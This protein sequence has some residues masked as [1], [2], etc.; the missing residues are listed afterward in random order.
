MLRQKSDT[1]KELFRKINA[2]LNV[3]LLRSGDTLQDAYRKINRQLGSAYLRFGSDNI[4]DAVRK[5]NTRLFDARVDLPAN[6]AALIPGYSVRDI[7]GTITIDWAPQDLVPLP[8]D[9]G[10]ATFYW[11]VNAANDSGDGLTPATAKGFLY[12]AFALG[13]ASAATS[14]SI[15]MV[16]GT[17]GPRGRNHH[18]GTTAVLPTKPFRLYSSDGTDVT[19]IAGTNGTWT[20]D[21]G[22]TYQRTLSGCGEVVDLVNNDAYGAPLAFTKVGSQATCRSTP[23]SW[24][25]SGTITYVNRGDA[26]A[27]TNTNT[28]CLLQATAGGLKNTTSG[29]CWIENV[30][31]VGGTDG[32]FKLGGNA[33]GRVLLKNCSA[34]WSTNSAGDTDGVQALDIGLVVLDRCKGAWNDK[35]AFNFH[36][37]NS[38]VPKAVLVDCSAWENG[39][40]ATNTSCNGPTIHD[41]G[42]MLDIRGT[43]HHNQGASCAH[44]NANTEAAHIGTSA[45]N[46]YG[47]VAR[48]GTQTAGIGFAPL[49]GSTLYTRSC[50]GTTTAALGGTL[51]PLSLV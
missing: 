49:T 6:I 29:N 15:C 47:D 31:F 5:L 41:G 1:Y 42:K 27:V 20:L 22:T 2:Q 26:A 50:T 37:A 33:T 43:Y 14:Y 30:R 48:G 32:C 38:S 16:G 36:T 34:F 40:F 3:A 11:N 9:I 19:L 7:N 44:I 39:R 46:D 45:T 4:R 51:T 25:D 24:Y 35:D 10:N 18:N 8:A 13:E 23:G 17:V 28:A 12:S 21:Q